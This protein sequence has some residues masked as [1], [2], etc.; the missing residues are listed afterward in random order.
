MATVT[1]VPESQAAPDVKPIY[2]G[3][4]EK[5]GK[6]PNFFAMLAHVPEAL[7]NFMP[8]YQAITGEGALEQ[9]FKELAYL[10]T[11]ITNACEY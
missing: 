3:L 9:R 4:K 10:K 5:L 7:K 2:A 11:S 8:M 1:P 6:V